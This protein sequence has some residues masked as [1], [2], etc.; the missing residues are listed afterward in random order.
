MKNY[1]SSVV[2]AF[3]G[4][5][6]ANLAYGQDSLVGAWQHQETQI[7]GGPNEGTYNN[8]GLIVF[9]EGHYS[10][11][12]NFGDRP[13]VPEGAGPLQTDEL[14]LAAFTSFRSNAGTYEVSGSKLTY[15]FMLARNPRAVGNSPEFEYAIDGDTLTITAT[16]DQGVVSRSTYRR[17]D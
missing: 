17:V 8:L 4:V 16:N 6:L 13:E 10:N 15:N 3:A 1:F 9:S 12:S 2:I 7:T 5:F 14:R 11:I